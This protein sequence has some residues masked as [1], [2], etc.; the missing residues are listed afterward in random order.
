M[1]KILLYLLLFSL[2][3]GTNASNLQ[4]EKSIELASKGFSNSSPR[5]VLDVKGNPIVIWGR[6]SDGALFYSKSNGTSFSNPK[7]LNTISNKI[8]IANWM[9]PQI[10]SKGDTIYIVF[11]QA[12]EDLTSS[13]IYICSSFD[14]GE[15]FSNPKVVDNIND[16]V[17]RFPTVTIDSKGNPIVGFMKLNSK[18][19]ESRWV[20]TSSN[21]LG[22]TF[23]KDIKVSG[24]ESAKEIC[25]CCPG[26]VVSKDN[27]TIMLY[28]NNQSNIRDSWAGI[29]KDY[30]KSFTSGMNVDK[31]NWNLNSCPAS[32]P[33]GVIIGDTL[34]SVF[35]NGF[36]GSYLSYF[37]KSAISSNQLVSTSNISNTFNGLS[38]QNYPRISNFNNSVAIAW[39][40]ISNGNTFIPLI[41]TKDIRNGLPKIYDT[42]AIGN[43]SNCDVALS[44]SKVFAVWEDDN[45]GTIKITSATYLSKNS[46]DFSNLK[47]DKY[48]LQYLS[49]SQLLKIIVEEENFSFG[50]T[51]LNGKVIKTFDVANNQNSNEISTQN[52]NKGVYL[53]TLE[54][55]N[56]IFSEKIIIE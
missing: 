35:L 15:N 56:E 11:K 29:S 6:G 49:E 14:G 37:S 4:W 39:K 55:G 45:S 3:N 44:D 43:I 40:Q 1:K 24:W 8:A 10:A 27:V 25:D 53:I 26:T 54:F 33:D 17:S 28:R 41:F 7:Q 18:F 38:Q 5:I 13:H 48:K 51:D 52:W 22:L 12:P 23:E 32:G 20:V 31:L 19:G 47:V 36:S 42:L 34:Y 21:D 50:I 30:G 2:Y 46:I 16:S 9:G